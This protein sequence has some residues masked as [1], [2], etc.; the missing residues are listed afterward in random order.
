MKIVVLDGFTLN[1][2][3]LSWKSFESL[4][5]CNIYDYSA[6]EEIIP[7]AK[8]ADIV[9]TNKAL[10]TKEVIDALPG[11][12]YIGVLATGYNVVDIET[13]TQRNIP[14]T[15]VPAYSAES[16]A[17]TAFSHMLNLTHHV[18]HHDNTVKDG[19]WSNSRDFSY[20]D[21]PL[22]E[23]NDLILGIVGL[24]QIGQTVA[25]IGQAFGMHVMAYDVNPPDPLPVGVELF[26]FEVLLEYSDI[27]TL[28]CPLTA[29][30]IKMIN[31]DSLSKMKQNAY[32]INTSRGGL[33]DEQALADALN[34]N[35]IAG[36]GLDVLSDEPPQ[37]ENP[38][39][40]A[41]NCY[42]TPHI[43]WAS[44]AARQRLMDIAVDNVAMFLD[45]DPQNVVNGM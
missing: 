38:L 15:N 30:N 34:H 18:G 43:A 2:G 9:L 20:W 28:H 27:V 6:P 29:D 16:V 41:K 33:I 44:F 37:S 23:I 4:G 12:K 25:R 42:I 8:D 45:G 40:N 19:K 39:I 5:E 13:A 31:A 7:R 24:G 26:S 11:L 35:Q 14:V 22:V 1:P 3:D 21:F 36:A 17:Q 32:L 10:L